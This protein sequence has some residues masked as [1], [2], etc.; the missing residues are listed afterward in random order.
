MTNMYLVKRLQLECGEDVDPDCPVELEYYL[1]ESENDY[2]DEATRTKIYGIGITKKTGEE[3]NEGMLIIDFSSCII[4]TKEVLK[5]LANN[6]VT[7]VALQSVL[8][9][10]VNS[11]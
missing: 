11:Y 1:A 9:D 5:K 4:R 7:P 3:Y 10:F 8:E 6:S 2:S